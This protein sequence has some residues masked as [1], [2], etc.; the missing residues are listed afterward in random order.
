MLRR[1]RV[2]EDEHIP[3]ELPHRDGELAALSSALEPALAGDA[4]A[5]VLVSG[6][7]GVG[8]TAL[9]R[10][11]LAKLDDYATTDHVHV[12]CLGA[13]RGDIVRAILDQHPRAEAPPTTATVDEVVAALR[14]AV[15]EP[16]VAICD[17][18]DSLAGRD[19][20]STL[21]L[22]NLSVI[23]V[24]HH[25]D[26]WLF[27][28]ST[29]T[30]ERIGLDLRL[31]RYSV[32]E[33]ADILETR[34]GL[35]LRAGAVERGQLER[36]ADQAAGVARV[37]IQ[38]LRSAAEVAGERGHR[39]LQSEDIDDSYDRARTRIR[40]SNLASLTLHHQVFYE[41]IRRAGELRA[42]E[43]NTQYD[44]I[45]DEV[46]R[47][48]PLQPVDGRDRRHKL[49]KLERYD[50]ISREGEGRGRTHHVVDDAVAADVELPVKNRK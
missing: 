44:A 25:A 23:V 8:K 11:A 5:D 6:P 35:G 12:P 3:R 40:R 50:L 31:D 32:D 48:R 46:Y 10:H 29:R 49:V 9:T 20:L 2:F 4:A 19:V 30:R 21:D 47:G 1:D 13:S 37:G 16:L 27:D 14:V 43:L 42:E 7:S 45:A 36:I 39:T 24:A 22:P 41:L 38:H 15:D 34:A 33:L 28:A 18:A 17:E 26:E